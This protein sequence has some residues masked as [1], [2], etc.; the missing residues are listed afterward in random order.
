MV[1]S[2]EPTRRL[3]RPRKGFT[4][5]EVLVVMSI[6]AILAGLLLPALAKARRNARHTIAVQAMQAISIALEG[7]RSDW[8]AY[9][10][11]DKFAGND[12]GSKTLYGFLCKRLPH[13]EMHCGPYLRNLAAERLENPTGQEP[14]LLSPI[15]NTET[16]GYYKYVLMSDPTNPTQKLRCLVID[17]GLDG[18]WGGEVDPQVGFVENGELNEN[19][20]FAHLDNIYSS[21]L[22]K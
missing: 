1:K 22:Q 14:A 5:I 8:G 9:P 4:L 21:S 18:L 10:P 13:G 15:N 20:T 16:K 6:I 7:Y 2:S 17:A 12:A 19:G 11:D 3:R